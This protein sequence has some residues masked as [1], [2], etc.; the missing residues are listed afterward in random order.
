MK[1]TEAK[2][3]G[4]LGRGQSLH[5][6]AGVGQD[7]RCH[8]HDFAAGQCRCRRCKSQ[9]AGQGVATYL[10]DIGG[11]L[12]QQHRTGR[13]RIATSSPRLD[14]NITDTRWL[15]VY[16]HQ[17]LHIN[18]CLT[19]AHQCL[20]HFLHT[21]ACSAVGCVYGYAVCAPTPSVCTAYHCH[22]ASHSVAGWRTPRR[23]ICALVLWRC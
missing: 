18:M 4:S 13:G 11:K 12:G 2:S 15:A 14:R 8:K 7:N 3:L 19:E 10:Q 5:F 16:A 20:H 17:R 1:G 6:S 23:E 9:T 22:A 21:R